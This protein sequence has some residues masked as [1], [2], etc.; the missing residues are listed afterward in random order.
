[1][2]MKELLDKVN[3]ALAAS[4]PIRWLREEEEKE[5]DEF[6]DALAQRS[7]GGQIDLVLEEGEDVL[8]L[9]F[10][11]T[12][13]EWVCGEYRRSSTILERTGWLPLQEAKKDWRIRAWVRELFSK[14]DK[15][16]VEIKEEVE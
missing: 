11:G 10:T 3:R 6:I 15:V 7:K 8:V 4:R 16:E 14:E 2:G 5:I 12:A 13:E 9:S 1:M